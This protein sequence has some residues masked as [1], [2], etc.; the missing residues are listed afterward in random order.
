MTIEDKVF[1]HLVKGLGVVENPLAIV[2][3]V[4]TAYKDG[5]FELPGEREQYYI[6]MK[7]T[8]TIN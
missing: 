3:H 5:V 6:H 4:R 8:A 1:I 7:K 2:R